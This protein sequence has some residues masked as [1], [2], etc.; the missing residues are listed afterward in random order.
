MTNIATKPA[1]RAIQPIESPAPVVGTVG[2]PGFVPVTGLVE[3][4]EVDAPGVTAAV[5]AGLAVL[6]ACAVVAGDFGVDGADVAAG[7][8]AAAVTVTPV[9]GAAVGAVVGA[10]VAVDGLGVGLGADVF[11]GTGVSVA[12]GTGV[13]NASLATSV[14]VALILAFTAAIC[15]R[16]PCR[17]RKITAI[18]ISPATAMMPSTMAA[19][20]N[21]RLDCS[22]PLPPGSPP[23]SMSFVSV[24]SSAMVRLVS[25][26]RF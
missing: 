22:S 23:T 10:V 20:R 6:T 25:D 15:A 5:P 21:V 8:V 11:V 24:S 3:V 17:L 2:S 16:S 9:V 1:A 12:S 18:K 4:I 13:I 26:S 14:F 19:M 7:P